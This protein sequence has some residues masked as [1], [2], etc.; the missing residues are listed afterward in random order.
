MWGLVKLIGHS[1][2]RYDH[3]NLKQV[4][5]YF[6][7]VFVCR[8]GGNAAYILGTLA[9]SE[10]G[11]LRVISLTESKVYAF[12]YFKLDLSLQMVAQQH[13]EARKL[14]ENL[15]RMLKYEDGESVMNAAGTMG[16]LVLLS[17]KI[18]LSNKAYRL[19][20]MTADCGCCRSL[21]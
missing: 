13:A 14:L 1:N 6:K 9:E 16:T 4:T 15:T 3:S 18:L 19:K 17:F 7:L 21:A 12:R 8:V 5:V 2:T 10:S 11:S 20:A